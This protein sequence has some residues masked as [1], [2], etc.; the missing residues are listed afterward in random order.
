MINLL[1]AVL[2]I[3]L[4][5]WGYAASETPSMTALIPTFAGFALLISTRWVKNGN[6]AA[7]RAALILTIVILVGLVKPLL[8][9][10]DRESF[11]AFTRVTIMIASGILATSFFINHLTK[12]QAAV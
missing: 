12:P 1:N 10:V 6:K 8:G 5:F 9:A 11:A 3:L 4:S 2:L 7:A